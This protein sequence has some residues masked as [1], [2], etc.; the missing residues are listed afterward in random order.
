M[1]PGSWKNQATPFQNELQHATTAPCSTFRGPPLA[2]YL[3]PKHRDL[4]FLHFRSWIGSQMSSTYLHSSCSDSGSHS[5]ETQKSMM[6]HI[7]TRSDMNL[8]SWLYHAP[9]ALSICTRIHPRLSLLFKVLLAASKHKD[10]NRW[11]TE[12]S[13]KSYRKLCFSYAYF[14]WFK[15]DHL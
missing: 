1:L 2:S 14:Y 4:N 10:A 15:E 8:K 5:A 9:K 6:G 11:S 3:G 13:K 7:I 12:L